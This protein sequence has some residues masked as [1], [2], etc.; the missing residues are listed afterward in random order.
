MTT[1]MSQVTCSL[2]NMKMDKLKRKEHSVSTNHLQLCKNVKDKIAAK[3]FEMLFNACPE[4]SKTFN[5]K[6]G[7]TH[8]FGQLYFSTKLSREKFN[9]LCSH[10]IDNSELEGSLSSDFQTFIP[11]VTADIGETFF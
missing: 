3:F 9:I 6:T 7:K 4:K 8:E 1:I 5:L 11:N 2:C 10:S